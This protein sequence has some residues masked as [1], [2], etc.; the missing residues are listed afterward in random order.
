MEAGSMMWIWMWCALSAVASPWADEAHSFARLET[1][2]QWVD[3]AD[4]TGPAAVVG[5]RVAVHYTGMLEDGTVFDSSH[6]RGQTFSF[7]IGEHQVITGWEDGLVGASAGT[8]RR[9]IIPPDQGYADRA[10]GAIPPGSTLYFEVEVVQVFPPRV[11]PDAPAA[12]SPADFRVRKGL[13]QLDVTVGAGHKPVDGERVCVDYAV[14]LG[15][16]LLAHTFNHERCMWF[17]YEPGK[18]SEGIFEGLDDMRGGGTRLLLLSAGQAVDPG[19]MAELPPA[20][21]VLVELTLV[22]AKV[23]VR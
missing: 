23:K 13:H 6:N 18:V 5:A 14:W 3:L 4:G 17:R 8:T 21:Q 7:R 15:A 1:G 20:S 19:W 2:V 16:E 9:L 12:F 22:E 11:V 10:S